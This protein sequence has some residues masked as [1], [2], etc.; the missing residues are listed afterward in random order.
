MLPPPKA[1]SFFLAATL[2]LHAPA[3]RSVE[4]VDLVDTLIGTVPRHGKVFPGAAT[5]SGLVQLS[6]DTYTGGDL[7]CGY[8]YDHDSIEGFSFTHMSGVGA[9]GDLGNLLVT[10]TT[11][12]LR[13][14]KGW[15]TQERHREPGYRSA[16]RHETEVARA[17][18]YAVTL[19]DYQIRAEMTAAPHS[20]ILR[21][22]FP[23]HQQSRIQIDLARRTGGASDRQYFRMVD[24]H[25]LEGWM[26]VSRK[27][28]AWADYTAYFHAKFSRPLKNVGAWSAEI[29]DDFKRGQKEVRSPKFH[30]MCANAKVLPGCRELEGKHI[31]FFTQFESSA[32]EVVQVKAGIS[33]VSIEGARNNLEK[34]IPGWEFDTVRSQARQLWAKALDKIE[35]QGGTPEQQRLFYTAL[36][37]T[38]I[39][40]RASADLDGAYPGGGGVPLKT[41]RYTRRTIFS[42]WDVF[43]S[44]FPLQTIINPS[45]VRDT[46][47]SLVDLAEESGKGY[48]VRWEFFN[49]YDGVMIA[50]PAV[51]VLADAYAKGIRGYDLERAYAAARASCEKFCNGELGYGPRNIST[52]LEYA[53]NEWCLSRL[54][55]ALGKKE[56]AV[57]Y[58]HRAQGYRNVFDPQFGWFHPKDAKG[59]W[60]APTEKGRLDPRGS[61]ESNWGQQGWF[62]P[63]DVPGLASLLGGNAQAAAQLN[64]FFENTP[65]PS[66]GNDYYNHANEVVHLAPFLFN[67][68]GRPWLTQKWVRFVC[69]KAYSDRPDGLAGDDDVGQMTAWYILCSSGLHQACPGDPRYEIF[70]PIFDRITYRIDPLYGA[71][72]TFEIVTRGNASGERY[73]QSAKLNGKPL[74]RCWIDHQ[75]IVSGG[76]LEL[77][78]GEKPNKTWGI[79]ST[80][81][82]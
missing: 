82:Q 44:Q 34:E 47:H 79:A 21:F 50:N 45:L 42:G 28:G 70:T 33:F 15:L 30:E 11:G 4:P 19:E 32:N 57:L 77:E 46:I 38:M 56:D 59:E 6:P 80:P 61:V 63:H 76:T 14:D 72:R 24:D 29:P 54:A 13:T 1:L 36:Y 17:G 22:T 40:P 16:Y 25:T 52:T 60:L 73:I 55:A 8:S 7:G 41:D 78:L 37:R 75:E 67:R 31:G 74:E 23:S 18:Y 5:P 10:P 3:V 27:G 62:V 71:G 65:D 43:R 26:K 20:G 49:A 51:V 35:V 66:V 53:H 9:Y 68:L 39:D 48:F 64:T 69:E 2:F 81:Q 12:P 58:A